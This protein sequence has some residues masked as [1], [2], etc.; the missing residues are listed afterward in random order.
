[1]RIFGQ[2]AT[3]R[4]I[5]HCIH[6]VFKNK[7]LDEMNLG[8]VIQELISPL[9]NDDTLDKK[10][11]DNAL[12]EFE[13]QLMQLKKR[14]NVP[15]A[16]PALRR[17]LK[18]F[19]KSLRIR[20]ESIPALKQKI[21]RNLN[22]TKEI[23]SDLL[24]K[25]NQG[26]VFE[27]SLGYLEAVKRSNEIS[28]RLKM[29]LDKEDSCSEEML[30]MFDT[31]LDIRASRF[32]MQPNF[33]RVL[34]ARVRFI[35]N[36]MVPKIRRK[37]ILETTKMGWPLSKEEHSIILTKS[38]TNVFLQSV[39][40][41]SRLHEHLVSIGDKNE[42]NVLWVFQDLYLPLIKRF[43]FHFLRKSS[44][45]NR[46]DRPEWCFRYILRQIRIHQDFLCL[47]IKP[48]LR[49]NTSVER[50]LSSI[51]ERDAS[52]ALLDSYVHVLNQHLRIV[53]PSIL[54]LG[55]ESESLTKD[56]SQGLMSVAARPTTKHV[57]AL[58]CKTVS[59]MLEFNRL[60]R[61][62]FKYEDS[63]SVSVLTSN[64]SWLEMWLEAE[65]SL[66]SS[67]LSSLLESDT[68][69]LMIPNQNECPTELS[70]GVCTLLET[71]F[72]RVGL[73]PDMSQQNRLF[74]ALVLPLLYSFGVAA[75]EELESCC[76]EFQV[77]EI[78]SW[79]HLGAVVS[80]SFSL[81]LPSLSSLNE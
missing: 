39:K 8:R 11:L 52:R 62:E 56:D 36:R 23:I 32:A 66:A 13:S 45:I 19:D 77:L 73:L 14:E 69:W 57:Q 63:Q 42:E 76:E 6:V 53:F 65:L 41:Q 75:R 35:A 10:S 7:K 49:E 50:L 34:D 58:L 20:K 46:I 26:H 31:L 28:D 74:N 51:K 4:K 9:D 47:K 24:F 68:A 43:R 30:N 2:G 25:V 27:I 29:K 21:D 22:D 12:K 37:F 33:K 71:S 15:D 3:T 18:S 59:E 44:R 1:V 54:S 16:L 78:A 72:E 55:K 79:K 60:L 70:L 40:I 5:I 17:K 81:S 67:Q 38:F 48:L 61:S 80:T 64:V